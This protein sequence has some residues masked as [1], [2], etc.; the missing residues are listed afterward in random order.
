[1]VGNKAPSGSR[2]TDGT[3]PLRAAPGHSG[4]HG[5]RRRESSVRLDPLDAARLAKRQLEGEA[6]GMG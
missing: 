4:S 5:S 1:M 2:L 3:H 6:A